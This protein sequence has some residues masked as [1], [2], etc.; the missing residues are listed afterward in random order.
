MNEYT[1]LQHS[2]ADDIKSA[3]AGLAGDVVS[4]WFP[5]VAS[6]VVESN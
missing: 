4:R 2:S 6:V 5:G 3:D 1:I